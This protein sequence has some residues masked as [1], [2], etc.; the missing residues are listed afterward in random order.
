MIAHGDDGRVV[1]VRG[2][3]PGERVAARFTKVK[4]D[5]AEAEIVE[6]LEPSSERVAAPCEFVEMGCGGCGWQHAAP[7][8]QQKMRI[9]IVEE[10]LRRIGGIED[11]IIE[12]AG[13]P[14][15][16]TTV[17]MMSDG[18]GL[19]FRAASSNDLVLVD[20][21]MVAHDRINE[22]IEVGNFDT[23][24]EFTLRVG[25]NT[26]ESLV[27]CRP[28]ALSTQ[29]DGATVVGLD[30][31]KDGRRVWYFEEVA[32]QR[33]RISARSF[34][35]S[36]VETAETLLDLV[37]SAVESA[38]ESSEL[39]DLYG[40]VGLFS[41]ILARDRAVTLVEWNKSSI[42]DARIN[43]KPT[44]SAKIVRSDVNAYQSDKFDVVVADPP[45]TGLRAPGVG[46]IAAAEPNTVVLVSCDAGPLGRD[47]KLLVGLGYSLE[48]VTLLNAFPHTPHVEVVSVFRR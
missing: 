1:F 35:Q 22:M 14:G 3:L 42:A 39:L 31:L 32:G 8:F 24:K 46:V 4:K 36:S 10:S 20:D 45:R 26:G 34:F 9:A 11:V 12:T 6:V 29:V 47:A 28:K 37:V 21:C 7:E 18:D 38:E 48:K 5:F 15:L 23:A 41:G 44:P 30:Q 13:K 25:A 40:G 16:R 27:I 43:L 2:G 33:W 19:G 17:R